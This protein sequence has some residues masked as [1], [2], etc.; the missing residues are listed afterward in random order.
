METTLFKK[1]TTFKQDAY[2]EHCQL[3]MM[4]CFSDDV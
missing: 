4:E 3:S 2:L 1:H